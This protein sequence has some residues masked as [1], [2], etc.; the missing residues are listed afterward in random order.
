MLQVVVS[1]SVDFLLRGA[2]CL[3]PLLLWRRWQRM[4]TRPTWPSRRLCLAMVAGAA[5]SWLL[6]LFGKVMLLLGPLGRSPRDGA[7]GRRWHRRQLERKLQR[8]GV[9]MVVVLVVVVVVAVLMEVARQVVSGCEL[10]AHLLLLLELFGWS[11]ASFGGRAQVGGG[12]LANNLLL[13]LLLAAVTYESR[14]LRACRPLTGRQEVAPIDGV[15]VELLLLLLRL[16]VMVVV[17]LVVVVLC[18]IGAAGR[19]GGTRRG[20]RG[21]GGAGGVGGADR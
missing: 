7:R 17:V 10:P 5:N 3:P 1:I 16:M 14:A 21:A 9:A 12:G 19:A 6:L 11:A 13:Q 4:Q 8:T 15:R 18:W 2:T 20:G